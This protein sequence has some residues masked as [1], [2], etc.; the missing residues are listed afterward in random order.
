MSIQMTLE[1]AV[2]AA[3]NACLVAYNCML[4]TVRT[5]Q[6][7]RFLNQIRLHDFLRGL[8]NTGAKAPD[9]T[10][11][12]SN[13]ISGVD[14]EKLRKIWFKFRN[15]SDTRNLS[16]DISYKTCSDWM[17]LAVRTW[18]CI[19]CVKLK[20]QRFK[21][22][23]IFDEGSKEGKECQEWKLLELID[24][25]FNITFWKALHLLFETC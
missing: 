24:A 20:L 13:A 15:R 17:S 21:I 23:Q 10:F 18:L 14:M 2:E 5:F 12:M 19:F 9:Y 7:R 1:V 11:K 8:Q 6:C 25:L 4:A 3:V 22:L 16:E